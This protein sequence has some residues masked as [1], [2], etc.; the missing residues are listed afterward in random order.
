MG[1][2]TPAGIGAGGRLQWEPPDGGNGFGR[3]FF[4]GEKGGDGGIT[5]P[6][7]GWPPPKGIKKELI[8]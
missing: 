2:V 4:F 3:S 1:A 7:K 5:L 6:Y 8:Q